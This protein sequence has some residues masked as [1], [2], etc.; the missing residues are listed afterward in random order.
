M[1]VTTLSRAIFICP[2]SPAIYYHVRPGRSQSRKARKSQRRERTEGLLGVMSRKVREACNLVNS[3]CEVI[4]QN[5]LP[6]RE[7][8]HFF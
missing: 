8:Y 4:Y 5:N 7:V 1:N 3:N 6:K 2:S